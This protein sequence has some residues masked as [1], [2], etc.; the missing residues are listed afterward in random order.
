[1]LKRML[2]T[3]GLELTAI[4]FGA[5]AIG[6]GG[7]EFGWGEQDDADSIAAIHR[8]LDQGVNWIDTAPAYG[9]GRSEEVIGKALAG[10]RHEVIL[11]TKCGL[12][13][14][15]AGNVRRNGRPERIRQEVEDSLRRLNTDVID[16]YQIHWPDASTPIAESWGTMA[17]LVREGKVRAIGVSN[18]SVA[19]MQEAQAVHPIASLQPPY[20]LMRR[21]IEAEILPFCR[22]ENIGVVAYSPM[23]SGLLTERF[24]SARLPADDWRLRDFDEGDF[25]RARALVE[26]LKPLAHA[27][28]RTVG[29]LAVAWVNSQPGVTAAIVGARRPD[30]ADE[31]VSGGVWIL[32]AAQLAAIDEVLAAVP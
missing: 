17:E 13:W 18:F 22:R 12:E 19:Q 27:A 10:R 24:D 21:G 2:G 28:G 7:W 15:S 8:S 26:R 29:Q 16:L 32:D 9:M 4:G 5:W 20:S 30:Q 1:M 23:T 31:N 25:R 6:G 14:D 11:A 3:S